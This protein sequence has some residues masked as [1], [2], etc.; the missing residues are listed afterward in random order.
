MK[1]E[2]VTTM[3]H[4]WSNGFTSQG[5]ALKY[6]D[7]VLVTGLTYRGFET[8]VYEF[9]EDE[10]EAGIS[11]IECRL[12]LRTTAPTPFDDGRDAMKWCF[13]HLND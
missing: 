8:A 6:G 12:N 13:D 3:E 4:L 2:Q 11:Y 1:W 7:R 5:A 9:I 10:E